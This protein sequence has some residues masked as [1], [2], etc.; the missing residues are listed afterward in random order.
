[1]AK[2][3]PGEALDRRPVMSLER[4]SFI[5]VGDTRG[6]E[7]IGA[8]DIRP[9]SLRIAQSGSPETKKADASKFIKGLQEGMFFNSLTKQIYGE[10]P[11]EIVIVNTLGHRNVEFDPNDKS[12]VLDFNV[13]DGDPRTQFTNQVVDG[14]TKRIKPKATLFYDYLILL[15]RETGN[16]LMTVSLKS[17]QL[18]KAKDLNTLLSGSK[19]PVF[20]FRFK[21]TPVPERKGTYSFYG[22][23]IEPLGYVSEAVYNEA[24]QLFTK[25]QGKTIVV[26]TVDDEAGGEG[27][28]VGTQ[29]RASGAPF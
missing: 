22:W 14:V 8:N 28:V 20:S 25:F 21:A 3:E 19:M 16:E 26:E 6:T 11:V 18:R 10:E 7:S 13:P 4:P 15:L 27:E 2:Q 5:K 1:M 29:G 9:P 24:D 12:V 23:L 17:T